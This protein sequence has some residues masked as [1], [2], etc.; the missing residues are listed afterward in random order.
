MPADRK[1]SPGC[2]I[3][4]VFLHLRVQN[5]GALTALRLL[6]VHFPRRC[7]LVP[8]QRLKPE[9]S[10]PEKQLYAVGGWLERL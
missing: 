5:E 1:V 2:Q 8:G 4:L 9:I 7:K 3:A 10:P 6:G